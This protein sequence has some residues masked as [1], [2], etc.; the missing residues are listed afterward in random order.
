MLI[1]VEIDID[2]SEDFCD[3]CQFIDGRGGNHCTIFL[4]DGY[5]RR[6]SHPEGLGFT[7][8]QECRE[9]EVRNDG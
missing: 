2:C 5:F 3:D 9:A 1:R 7:R 6:L 8:C 4:N